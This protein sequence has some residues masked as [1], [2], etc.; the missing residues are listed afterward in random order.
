MSAQ[1]PDSYRDLIDG[2]VVATVATNNPNG[3]PQL[4]VVWYMYDGTHVH[5]NTTNDRQ[6]DD[7]LRR[8]PHVSFLA[9]DP[10]NPYRYMEIRGEVDEIIEG[11]AAVQSI[12]ALAKKYVGV[13]NYYG[14]FQPAEQRNKEQRVL[15]KIKPT[16]VIAQ[17]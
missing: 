10:T 3:Q 16:K 1:I 15:Y 17:G 12:N 14:D 4:S 8:D 7:N 13:E 9:I 6:K 5:L 11:E 2:K